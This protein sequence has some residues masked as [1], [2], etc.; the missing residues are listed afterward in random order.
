MRA[1]G[2]SEFEAIHCAWHVD[3]GKHDTYIFSRLQNGNCFLGIGGFNRLITGV[4]DKVHRMQS[5][6]ELV[7]NDQDVNGRI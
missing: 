1:D 6:E 3:V 5:A 4:F 2:V 7:F